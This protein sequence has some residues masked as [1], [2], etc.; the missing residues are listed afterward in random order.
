[1]NYLPITVKDLTHLITAAVTML[2]DLRRVLMSVKRP[3]R[4]FN[5]VQQMSSATRGTSGPMTVFVKILNDILR[6]F[7]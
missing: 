1:M 2:L 3:L 4:I 7:V 6:D 5:A